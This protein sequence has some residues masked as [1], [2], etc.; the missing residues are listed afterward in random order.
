MMVRSINFRPIISIFLNLLIFK[1]FNHLTNLKQ[2]QL[3]RKLILKFRRASAN[4]KFSEIF[5]R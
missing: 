3:L 2:T 4:E 5:I 1:F